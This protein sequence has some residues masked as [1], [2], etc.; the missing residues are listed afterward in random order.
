[1]ARL[2]HTDARPFVAVMTTPR[3]R[4]GPLARTLSL[5][6][7]TAG[8][9][10]CGAGRPRAASAVA[11]RGQRTVEPALQMATHE[12]RAAFAHEGPDGL[13]RLRLHG[14]ELDAVFTREIAAA[15]ER[16][17]FG[18]VPGHGDRRWRMF[19]A[20]ARSDLVGFCARGVRLATA[21][22][23][24]GLRA[25]AWVVDRLLIIGRE[26]DGLWAAWVEGLVLTADGWRLS[27][28]VPFTRQV[29]APRRDHADLALWD[30]DVGAAPPARRVLTATRGA[31]AP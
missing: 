10:G 22:G 14:T 26:R 8:A 6:L 15:A 28:L 29:E 1:L 2:S 21:N 24:D 19:R 23:V 4:A 25:P 7:F 18:Q 13:L 3:R 11:L 31:R 16:S 17:P 27:P 12:L 20:L 30:C 5:G 9:L